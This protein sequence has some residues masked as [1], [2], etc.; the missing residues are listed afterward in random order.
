MAK[1]IEASNSTLSCTKARWL[2]PAGIG[3]EAGEDDMAR[4]IPRADSEK[5][6]GRSM[7]GPLM[8]DKT[9]FSLAASRLGVED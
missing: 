7:T 9:G 3:E 8:C 1:R 6:K 4:I 5:N 2:R